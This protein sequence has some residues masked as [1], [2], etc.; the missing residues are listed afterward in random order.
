MS[1]AERL[2]ASFRDPSGFVF[3][4]HGNLLRQVNRS[5]ADNWQLLTT[6]G[7]LDELTAARLVVSH[8]RLDVSEG[9]DDSAIGVIR[10]EFVPF[11]SYPYEWS[12]SQLKDAA[13][14][15]LDIQ[16]RALARGMSLKDATAYNVQF[17]NGRPIFIDTLSFEAYKAGQPWVAY[18]QFC[19]HFLAPLALMALV[20]I[21][22]GALQR[23][24]LDGISLDLTARLLPG[25][26]KLR[27]GLAAHIHMHARA[28]RM[29]GRNDT[30]SAKPAKISQTASLALIDSLQGT[31]RSLS[32]QPEATEW[33]NYYAETNYSDAAMAE[34]HR[35]VAELL[36]AAEP[37]NRTCW[38]LGANT[39]EF[40]QLA[41]QRAFNT[42]AVDSDPA[43]VEKAYLKVK[44]DSQTSILPLLNDLANPSPSQGWAE[45]ERESLI[46]RG[47]AGVVLGLA[48]I[49]HLA[50][51]NNIPLPLIA[52]YFAQIAEWAI[53]EFVP[54][55][56]S[57]VVR[58]LRS[59]EDVFADYDRTGFESAFE[60][61]FEVVRSS[62]IS[63]SER[64]LFLLRRR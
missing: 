7:L 49:H 42:I 6:S 16:T 12:F 11:I 19:S 59:R 40:S 15:T 56:D 41:A 18:R 34:K 61:H 31:I 23:V 35:L 53:I 27:P 44:A 25:T 36:D 62:L 26:T 4:S 20:D 28:Q 43:A 30:P 17:L 2:A 48:L 24:H 10:P 50:I 54:K 63:G 57:Q 55:S 1:E 39:G 58:L 64:E 22:L 46:S 51:G 13:L 52:R 3:C 47:P 5:Y 32:W 9:L 38:D 45:T 33:G 37:S 60:A 14:L 21:R 29:D 8:E